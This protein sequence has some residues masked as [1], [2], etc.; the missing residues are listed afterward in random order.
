MSNGKQLEVY[1]MSNQR[2]MNVFA[3]ALLGTVVIASSTMAA[4]IIMDSGDPGWSFEGGI[5]GYGNG[6]RADVNWDTAYGGLADWIQSGNAH[7]LFSG[8]SAGEYDVY[9]SFVNTVPA[10]TGNWDSSS[11]PFSVYDGANYLGGGLVDEEFEDGDVPSLDL[12]YDN[13]SWTKIGTF[14]ITGSTMEVILT[15]PGNDGR[16]VLTDAVLINPVPEPA[17]VS[18]IGLGAIALL[19][20]RRA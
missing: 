17:T 3:A 4:P 13:Y 14:T 20:R 12:T 11:A 19:R 10:W 9:A 6:N 15:G 7:W 16:N 1:G 2:I 5:G 18:L 8:L